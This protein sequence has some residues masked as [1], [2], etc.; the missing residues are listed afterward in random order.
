MTT[1][2]ERLNRLAVGFECPTS[3]E[4]MEGDGFRRFCAECRRHVL[5]F[6][7]MTA[8]EIEAHLQASR[9]Q[10]CVRLTR[11]NGR[12]VVAP[13]VHAAGPD[14][15]PRRRRGVAVAAGLVSAWLGAAT[16]EPQAAETPPATVSSRIRSPGEQPAERES[17]STAG[18]VLRGRVLVEDGPALAGASLVARN[19]LDGSEHAARTRGD[20][21]FAFTG[22]P[23]GIYD[24]E[25]TLDGY[26]IESRTGIALQAGEQ[27]QAELTA[28]AHSTSATV[29]ILIA[30]EESLRELF[31]RSELVVAAVSVDPRAV[32]GEGRI[33]SVST[34][35]RIESVLKG[36]T[37]ER[38]VPYQQRTY[39]DSGDGD[40]PAGL[41]PGTQVLAFLE[42]E[43]ASRGG[44]ASFVSVGYE[45][46][47]KVDGA[48]RASYLARLEE[49]ARIERRAARRGESDPA[50]L[51]DWLVATVEDPLTRGE[52]TVELQGA[53]D[54]LAEHAAE[55]ATSAEVAA[56]DLQVLVER[57]R[58][59]GGT[60]SQ[61]PPAAVLGAFLT[62]SHRERLTAALV[63]TDHLREEDLAVFHMVR[64]W[65]RDA[66]IDWLV[67][68]L[69]SAEPAEDLEGTWWLDAL[70]EEL[71]DESLS[72]L[73]A[74]AD[75]R[76]EEI[77][78]RWPDDESESTDKLR[79][80]ARAALA[81]ELRRDCAEAL[82]ASLSP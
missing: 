17:T 60:L 25:G 59:D 70:A 33:Q 62:E 16:A 66:A 75:E 21:T 68:Q 1:R 81:R 40:W 34:D 52:A 47:K 51:A 8:A 27:R 38:T 67:R 61:D 57:F 64:A 24:V 72:A 30:P 7:G 32:V 37:A 20:G 44:R 46:L 39:G 76:E 55:A 50:D 53:F 69:R 41:A 26:S 9:G 71:E 79:D 13:P 18:A 42:R 19:A 82:A 77:N 3:W 31:D 74:A 54:A 12:L 23:A 36:A 6:E 28:L 10:L 65:D 5:D 15:P 80:E 45:G 78:T 2:S 48:Q 35:L 73:V 11:C 58:A 4:T 29:G 14:V 43:E 49:L 63:G 56:G 22:L